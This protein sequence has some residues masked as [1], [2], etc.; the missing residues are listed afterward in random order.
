MV[1]MKAAYLR[2]RGIGYSPMGVVENS[3]KTML[4]TCHTVQ[5]RKQPENSGEHW[6]WVSKSQMLREGVNKQTK[7]GQVSAD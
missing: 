5:A 3:E 2:Y 6:S 4:V 1:A 7:T